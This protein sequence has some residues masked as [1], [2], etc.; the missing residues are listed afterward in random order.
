MRMRTEG[1]RKEREHVS[2]NVSLGFR[3]NEIDENYLRT[4]VTQ[5]V[6]QGS[7]GVSTT[8][9]GHSPQNF[10]RDSFQAIHWMIFLGCCSEKRKKGSSP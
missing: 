8:I 7:R 1:S 10:P 2:E 6:M 3:L 5:G 4:G 9:C